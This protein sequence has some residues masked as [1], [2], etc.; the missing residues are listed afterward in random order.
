[1]DLSM[2][3][4]P[5]T[6]Q[7]I[8]IALLATLS[9]L[10]VPMTVHA[11]HSVL[12]HIMEIK[13]SVVHIKAEMA[14]AI[15]EK[16][17]LIPGPDGRMLVM[18]K[19]RPLYHK[20][21]GAGIV[22]SEGGLIVTNAHT[23]YKAGKI[24]VTLHDSSEYAASLET[25]DLKNDIALLKIETTA[26]LDSVPLS[27]APS[28]Q[29]GTQ[30]FSIGNSKFLNDTISGGTIKGYGVKKGFKNNPALNA[31]L[32]EIS[33]TVYRGDSGTPILDEQGALIGI[34][35]GGNQNTGTSFAVP[36][37]TIRK[38]ISEYIKQHKENKTLTSN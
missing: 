22:V 5:K 27:D 13:K 7:S 25:I 33:F 28:V 18:K 29:L 10:S 11:Q 14:A 36:A 3:H 19:T 1:M 21:E 16:P 20:R 17:K 9:Q 32:L 12:A 6:A 4:R 38:N 34:L 26:P 2:K 31:K 23:V 15:A 24:T 37:P 35:T 30:V 8:A